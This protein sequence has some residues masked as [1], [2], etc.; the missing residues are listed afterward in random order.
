MTCPTCSFDSP[1]GFRFCGRCGANLS[2]PTPVATVAPIP[3]PAPRNPDAERRQLTLLFC[4]LVGS[5]T[6]GEQLDPEE[7]REIV[8]E[9][10]AAC[11]A[12]VAP[13]GGHIA[14]Y[15]GDGILIYFGYPVASEDSP[16]R[17]VHAGLAILE[18]VSRLNDR[19]AARRPLRLAVRVGIH[20]GAVVTGGVGV[21]GRTEQLAIGSAPN[22]AARLQSLADPDT[23]V[24]SGTTYRL[25]EG[26]FEC[27]SLGAHH[28]KGLSQT[29]DVYRAI[30]DT[31]AVSRFEV[32]ATAIAH[33]HIAGAL[34]PLARA[35]YVRDPEWFTVPLWRY[36]FLNVLTQSLRAGHLSRSTADEAVRLAAQRMAPR[37][38]Q[39]DTLRVLDLALTHKIT[40]YDAHYVA[41]A[42]SLNLPLLT[43]D[44]ELLQKFPSTAVSLAAF[45]A[46]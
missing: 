19:V 20:T 29:V 43:E 16:R 42:Q 44:R 34:N 27:V 18:E 13:F 46:A 28:L 21:V 22:V 30:R 17:A 33:L 37:E 14:Q 36:E 9:Y 12:A 6:M 7:L 10:Q 38:R 15:L 45:T 24:L 25:V 1:A 26:F 23:V 8:Q 39:P 31:G 11:A 2:G 35:A 32:T 41:L 3:P 4:D 40:G 5:T